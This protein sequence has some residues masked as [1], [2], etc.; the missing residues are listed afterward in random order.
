M[1]FKQRGC[2]FVLKVVNQLQPN[3]AGC[4]FHAAFVQKGGKKAKMCR[5]SS[6]EKA[7]KGGKL[8]A[9]VA[10]ISLTRGDT[11]ALVDNCCLNAIDSLI[12]PVRNRRRATKKAQ[13]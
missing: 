11:S 6:K 1:D 9:T 5:T 4:F 12:N 3:L 10:A 2:G 13:R 8:L 7:D